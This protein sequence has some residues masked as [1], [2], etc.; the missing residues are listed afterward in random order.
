VPKQPKSEDDVF[1]HLHMVA[2]DIAKRPIKI[3]REANVF[4]LSFSIPI[5]MSRKDIT[6][7]VIGNDLISLMV[8]W[9]WLM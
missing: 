9:Y 8:L 1:K 2:F 4:G 7:V 3:T 5:Y 6:K